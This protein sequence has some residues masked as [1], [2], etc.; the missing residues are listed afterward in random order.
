MAAGVALDVIGRRLVQP[1]YQASTGT[2]LLLP[3]NSRKCNAT[4]HLRSTPRATT[5][6]NGNHIE[7]HSEPIGN[8]EKVKTDFDWSEY[9]KWQQ[10]YPVYN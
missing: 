8:K 5:T 6:A 4:S 2:F 10:H 1:S 7:Q 9:G 3:L